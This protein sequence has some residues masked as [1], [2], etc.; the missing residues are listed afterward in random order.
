[1]QKLLEIIPYVSISIF[2]LESNAKRSSRLAVPVFKTNLRCIKDNIENASKR[3]SN[4][5]LE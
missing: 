2:I 5:Y 3:L 1:M 4:I